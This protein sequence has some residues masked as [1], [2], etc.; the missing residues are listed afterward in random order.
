MISSAHK[1][2]KSFT[3][4]LISFDEI[5]GSIKTLRRICAARVVTQLLL[6]RKEIAPGALSK[7]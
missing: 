4:P 6:Q 2:A 3:A 7:A 5:H 1:E